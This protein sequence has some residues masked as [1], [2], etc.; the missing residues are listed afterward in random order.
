VLDVILSNPS[1]DT[2]LISMPSFY[3]LFGNNKTIPQGPNA[4]QCLTFDKHLCSFP[5]CSDEFFN[6]GVKRAMRS[7]NKENVE[8][9]ND[10]Q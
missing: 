6:F 10:Q 5:H 1:V 7:F 2:S 8:D 3:C 4:V 9:K